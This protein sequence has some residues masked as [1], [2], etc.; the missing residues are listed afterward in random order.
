MGSW[1][2]VGSGSRGCI[3]AVPGSHRTRKSV[4]RLGVAPI[5]GHSKPPEQFH[6]KDFWVGMGCRILIYR[7]EAVLKQALA[8]AKV[9]PDQGRG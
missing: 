4:R 5:S 2:T 8:Y 1:A 9:G 7:K 3:D 6:R